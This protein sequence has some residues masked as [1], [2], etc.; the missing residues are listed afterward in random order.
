MSGP[1]LTRRVWIIQIAEMLPT[2][3]GARLMRSGLLA[4][5]FAERGCDVVWFTGRYDHTAKRQR[6]GP[7]M[8]EVMPRLSL[9]LLDGIGYS[10][11]VS[12]ARIL[13]Q[14]QVAWH[15]LR[16]A[17]ARPH[18]DLM[19]ISYPS[20][21]LAAAAAHLARLWR[22]PFVIDYRDAW[23]DIIPSYLPWWAQPLVWPI[24]AVYRFLLRFALR[25]CNQ[26]YATGDQMLACALKYVSARQRR[27]GFGL[28]RY[29]AFPETEHV[30]KEAREFSRDHPLIL[31]F[32]GTIGASY[33][34]DMLVDV[35]SL[36]H[37]QKEERIH[38]MVVGDGD[39]RAA[40]QEKCVSLPGITFAG[41]R[42]QE[43]VT[44]ALR[45]AHI[46]ALF[47]RGGTIS[48]TV[49]N[50][51][52][53]YLSY[54]LAIES[55]LPGEVERMLKSEGLGIHI[56][57]RDP[58]RLVEWLCSLLD[59]RTELSQIAAR[60]RDFFERRLTVDAV[61]GAMVSEMELLMNASAAN[62]I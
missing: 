27:P 41:W 25:S 40:L 60:A 17:K 62:S 31:L 53:E 37:R 4:R 23:P 9:V 32:V 20:P 21:E 8:Q 43:Y 38:I 6:D 26:L 55:N 18:P 50:K 36:L 14:A 15:F 19:V 11:N 22:V 56:H 57:P 52:A 2:D 58:A 1:E 39:E 59:D 48:Y 12:F 16:V 51:L 5:E 10:R 33:D 3:P 34:V 42:E 28:V 7:P 54:G 24:R 35:A 46:G 30:S 13:N 49:P 61:Y 29:L 44:A 47:Y 45:S